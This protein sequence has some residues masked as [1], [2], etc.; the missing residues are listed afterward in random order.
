LIIKDLER[1]MD[2]I[3]KEIEWQENQEPYFHQA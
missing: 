2:A 3:K 1:I